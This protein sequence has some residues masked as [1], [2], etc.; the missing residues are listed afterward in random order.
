MPVTESTGTAAEGMRVPCDNAA[1]GTRAVDAAA[2]TAPEDR[3]DDV[4]TFAVFLVPNEAG[5]VAI[6]VLTESLV[7]VLAST[8]VASAGA[9]AAL[10]ALVCCGDGLSE[11]VR[12][13]GEGLGLGL[14]LDNNP[15]GSDTD[16]AETT[17]SAD[18]VGTGV[19]APGSPIP[20]A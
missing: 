11:G 19:P 4:G 13:L 10:S 2:A 3:P 8:D 5:P 1:V 7:V 9:G 14:G 15:V 17:G 18:T 12:S 6:D 20:S 16:G